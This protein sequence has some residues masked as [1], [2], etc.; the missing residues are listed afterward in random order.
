MDATH[1]RSWN[2]HTLAGRLR[3]A[4]AV[5]RMSTCACMR[6]RMPRACACGPHLEAGTAGAACGVPH[7][8]AGVVGAA[9]DDARVRRHRRAA[10][11]AVVALRP[12]ATPT[13]T[14]EHHDNMLSTGCPVARLAGQLRSG[15]F[16]GSEHQIRGLIKHLIKHHLVC[17]GSEAQPP[18]PSTRG[19]PCAHAA[20]QGPACVRACVHVVAAP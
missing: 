17:T 1:C 19:R 4:A 8:H 18:H 6:V 11:R 13:A 2:M 5:M 20:L 15:K 12:A 10:H 7:A 16:E 3:L 14:R 9:D